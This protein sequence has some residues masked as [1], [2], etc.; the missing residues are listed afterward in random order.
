MDHPKQLY[1][2]ASSSGLSELMGLLFF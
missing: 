1:L 2:V